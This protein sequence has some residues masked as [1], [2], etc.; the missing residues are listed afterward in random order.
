M[1]KN[2]LCSVLLLLCILCSLLLSCGEKPLADIPTKT[3]LAESLALFDNSGN[4]DL[5]HSDAGEED[6]NYF[7]P[8]LAGQIFLGEYGAPIANDGVITEYAHAIPSALFAFEIDIFKAAD[9]AS[10]DKI[11]TLLQTRME[12]KSA[13]R[14]QIEHYL[15]TNPDSANELKALDDMEIWRIGNYVLL[16]STPNNALVKNTVS[17]RLG[18]SADAVVTDDVPTQTTATQTAAETV[19][20]LTD[21]VLQA[22]E[23]G[24]TMTVTSH[25]AP[26]RIVLGG[27]CAVGAKIHVEGGIKDYV[28]G[29]DYNSWLVEIEIK[30]KGESLLKIRQELDGKMSVPLT[31]EVPYDKSVD[32]SDHGIYAAL[33]GD[34]FQGHFVQQLDDWMGTNLLNEEQQKKMA[35]AIKD[36]VSFCE[37]FDT[38]LIYMIVPNQCLIYPETMP[39]RY[40]RSA[41]DYTLLDQFTA[42]AKEAGAIVLDLYP[43][44]EAHKNDEFKIYHK[45]DSHWT[46]YGAYWGC[47]TLITEIA[48]DYPDAVPMVIGEDISFYTKTV[49]AGDM[50]THFEIDNALVSE[51]ATFAEWLVD[52][53]NRPNI[54]VDN[55]CEIDNHLVADNQVIVNPDADGK[56]LPSA[57]I[58]RDSFSFNA[59]AY[60]NQAFSKIHWNYTWDYQFKKVDIKKADVDYLIYLVSEKSLSSILY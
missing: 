14:S 25:S 4:V 9:S 52:Y 47:H 19:I 6:D 15:S 8:G 51:N 49:E 2:R 31:V 46:D 21:P 56:N 24:F 20:E 34:N 53:P 18:A 39:D 3:L 41:A 45:T 28:F 16:L 35:R 44:M 54:Y 30:D 40:E 23:D 11:E 1:S 57:M 5:Y 36:K 55:R 12:I 7:D 59:F 13:L 17:T 48:K 10:A 29:T 27:T 60:L 38:K 58:I 43:V 37:N 22:A 32:F 26:D 50:M 33:M 42:A